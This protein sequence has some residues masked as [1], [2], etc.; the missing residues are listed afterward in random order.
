VVDVSNFQ[1]KSRVH[2]AFRVGRR[3]SVYAQSGRDLD[4][5]SEFWVPIG[6]DGLHEELSL[7]FGVSP[8]CPSIPM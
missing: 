1:A 2:G 5:N 7:G 4:V 8:R 3:L 6:D